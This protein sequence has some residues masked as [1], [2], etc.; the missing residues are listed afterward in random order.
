M[1]HSV[2]YSSDET[3]NF[4]L[5]HSENNKM[6]KITEILTSPVWWTTGIA[7]LGIIL[8]FKLYIEK[9]NIKDKAIEDERREN[10]AIEDQ[11][12]E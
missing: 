1:L 7:L 3:F 4:R 12:A 2:L 11:N 5:N 6:E 9:I 8:G 10:Q